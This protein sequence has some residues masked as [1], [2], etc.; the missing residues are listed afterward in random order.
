V[1]SSSP[2]PTSE[3]ESV[4]CHPTQVNATCLLFMLSLRALQAV[5]ISGDRCIDERW[6]ISPSS[7]SPGTDPWRRRSHQS[8]VGVLL[9]TLNKTELNV[10]PPPPRYHNVD[11]LETWSGKYQLNRKLRT[12]A[13]QPGQLLHFS[14]GHHHVLHREFIP[15]PLFS[16]PG[17]WEWKSPGIPGARETGAREWIP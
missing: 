2:E 16:F 10:R 15:G 6:T 9:P 4:T 14:S 8:I 7:H 5:P 17:I 13:V 12:L 1:Y 11:R 3:A